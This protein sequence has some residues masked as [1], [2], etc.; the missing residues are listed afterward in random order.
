[1]TSAPEPKP[2]P[3]EESELK[4]AGMF[5]N[6]ALIRWEVAHDPLTLAA[7]PQ[8]ALGGAPARRCAWLGRLGRYCSP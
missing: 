8:P 6:D 1:M 4:P 5:M 2:K 3:A 7:R